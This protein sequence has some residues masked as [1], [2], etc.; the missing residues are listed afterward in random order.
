LL[1]ASQ[2]VAQ[3]RS[4][5]G[6][7]RAS[8]VER[9]KTLLRQTDALALAA[10]S[11]AVDDRALADR[12]GTTDASL[13]A[14][15]ELI[16][17]QVALVARASSPAVDPS[18]ADAALRGA[19]QA[20]QVP[21][22]TLSPIDVILL[23]LA[24]FFA[25]LTG[26]RPDLSVLWPAVGMVGVAL[27]LFVVAT[28]GRGLRERVR[29][30]VALHDALPDAHPAP[31]RHLRAADDAIAAGRPRDAIRAL[32]MFA[33]TSLAAREVI[34]YDP[35]LTDGELIVR[36]AGIPNADALRDLIFA[37]ERAWFGLREPTSDEAQRARQL[38]VR[39]AG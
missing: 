26:P 1:E 33:L 29:T 7:A 4:S 28:L 31:S 20:A 36:A 15:A 18:R 35:A 37:Y 10:G 6:T 27:I 34:R 11:F 21:E 3:A 16:S 32:Y 23:A 19:I 13:D 38:A 2:L 30:E 25:G 17:A 22:Q 8:F 12:I 14:A 5:S 9:A 39:V 24:S